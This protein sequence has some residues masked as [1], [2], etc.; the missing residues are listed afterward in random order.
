[1]WIPY[2][3]MGL[4]VFGN[5]S[6]NSSDHSISLNGVSFQSSQIRSLNDHD[7]DRPLLIRFLQP[8]PPGE[9]EALQRIGVAFLEFLPPSGYLI[10]A[11]P[12]VLETL[13]QNPNVDFIAAMP[14]EAKLDEWLR[15][16]RFDPSVRQL[17]GERYLKTN[18]AFFPHISFMKAFETLLNH[19]AV[20]DEDA[21]GFDY[22]S[23]ML[24]VA[25]PR[26]SLHALAAEPGVRLIYEADTPMA[27]QNAVAADTSNIEE[28]LPGGDAGYEL[29][30]DGVM[31]GIWDAGNVLTDHAQLRGRAILEDPVT[32]SAS[33]HAT[34]VAGTIAASG[35]NKP[36]VKG[37]APKAR[38][39][40]YTM[41]ND[42]TEMDQSHHRIIA[43]NHSYGLA[44]GW[45]QDGLTGE[46]RWYGN[47]LKIGNQYANWGIYTE[48]SR[49][50]DSF[51]YNNNLIVV[52]AAGNFRNSVSPPAGATFIYN[53]GPYRGV[54]PAQLSQLYQYDTI[55]NNATGKNAIVIGAVND[56]PDDPATLN[57][58]SMTGFS[59]WGPT[60]D[61]RIKPDIVANGS[62]LFS[63]GH[64]D[65]SDYHTHSGTSM[66]APVV[67]GAVG[68]LT[69]MHRRVFDGV[70]PS[71]AL[72]RGLLIHTAIDD[73]EFIGPDYRFGWGLLNARAAAD[74]LNSASDGSRIHLG[75]FRQDPI[76]LRARSTG[77]PVKATL[78]W[79]DPP[80][81]SDYSVNS[82]DAANLV[83]DLD[84]SLNQ[85]DDIYWPWT[86]D[87]DDPERLAVQDKP[88]RLDN[89]EQVYIETAPSGEYVIR[90]D[91]AVNV[92][93]SQSFA[94]LLN[95]IQLI[96]EGPRIALHS[97]ASGRHESARAEVSATVFGSGSIENVTVTA[98]GET[99]PGVLFDGRS[100]SAVWNSLDIDTGVYEV[101]VEAADDQ[102][103]TATVY[104]HV[105]IDNSD[106][107]RELTLD[108]PALTA[109]LKPSLPRRLY[110][111]VAPRSGEY[112]F[113]TYPLEFGLPSDTGLALK[114]YVEGVVDQDIT[115]A[116]SGVGVMSRASIRLQAGEECQIACFA[117]NRGYGFYS[118]DV[119]EGRPVDNSLRIN[120][121]AN[122][123]PVLSASVSDVGDPVWFSFS[124]KGLD[125]PFITHRFDLEILSESNRSPQFELYER[126]SQGL[127]Y[128]RHWN[129]LGNVVRL[130]GDADYELRVV[131][132]NYLGQFR[133]ALGSPK[134]YPLQALDQD[135]APVT[136]DL[137][138]NAWHEA[139]FSFV[140][141]ATRDHAIYIDQNLDTLA[142]ASST[143]YRIDD[144][145]LT[146]YARP[147]DTIAEY[148]GEASYMIVA[149]A[150]GQ[151]GETD[152]YVA[153][154]FTV[155]RFY[156]LNVVRS[157][158]SPEFTADDPVDVTL[159]IDKNPDFRITDFS[160]YGYEEFSDGWRSVDMPREL[161][162]SHRLILM[163]NRNERV[164]YQ[165][166]PPPGAAEDA[167]VD[168]RVLVTAYSETYSVEFVYW[169]YV[170]GNRRLLPKPTAVRDWPLYD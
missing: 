49:A 109:E 45:D 74:L 31:L 33:Q 77:G 131:V 5:A 91:G 15:L 27:P 41:W 146:L 80:A 152:V 42:L 9:R 34:H 2:L 106:V 98:N 148:E 1:M 130:N 108:G 133:L 75:A 158:E 107:S 26:S 111:F 144:G 37:M 50:W 101:R 105:L 67:T 122:A 46:W 147:G 57:S 164:F 61:G 40:C 89:V 126:R 28:I 76:E 114:T 82:V 54:A 169:T 60:D 81:V 86:L 52:C 155:D 135:G 62:R 162:F 8:L 166:Q 12:D 79:I 104:S 161:D 85:E 32:P 84:L 125:A 159:I 138:E 83:N 6:A 48:R 18:I 13:A 112:T 120:V 163:N 14:A 11:E 4:L 142:K 143:V 116:D 56:L 151:A 30:G 113:E 68:L 128:V 134:T 72:M 66:A 110:T 95:G 102:G 90:I 132:P 115:D 96:D 94:L 103:R 123:G 29:T 25:V 44:V 140:P 3:I 139:W 51:V 141:S 137:G 16:S 99:L 10:F 53:D 117:E 154:D 124:T 59:S 78:S 170:R 88:N 145:E 58:V 43:S 157:F 93:G 87:P 97:P 118:I 153:S 21:I 55:L 71:A 23:T 136:L 39:L 129:A 160:V 167:V 20:P 127:S 7:S 64:E 156:P 19:G 17:Y 69:E 22:A 149:S 168:A 119:R 70:D 63:L 100:L 121:L 165:L 65:I 38:L 24:N 35:W 92:G 47:P 73:N 36:E 150:S